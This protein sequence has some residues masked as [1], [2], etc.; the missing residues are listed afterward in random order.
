MINVSFSADGMGKS[1]NVKIFVFD[2]FNRIRPILKTKLLPEFGDDINVEYS[3][4]GNLVTLKGKLKLHTPYHNM[5]VTAWKESTSKE[6]LLNNYLDAVLYQDM[7]TSD[8]HGNFE[9]SFK[10]PESFSEAIRVQISG[11][12]FA[13]QKTVYPIN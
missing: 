12:D 2:S 6:K 8:A 1:D 3:S 9:I 11:K 5:T 10:I 7:I 13:M 4:D